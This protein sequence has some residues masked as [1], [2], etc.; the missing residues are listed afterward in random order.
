MWPTFEILIT[1][2]KIV[3]YQMGKHSPNLV[4]LLGG[5]ASWVCANAILVHFSFGQWLTWRFFHQSTKL[6]GS[7]DGFSLDWFET[8]T[9]STWLRKTCLGALN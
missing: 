9:A 2:P 7:L 3:N 5:R 6:S 1:L 8:V 4:T